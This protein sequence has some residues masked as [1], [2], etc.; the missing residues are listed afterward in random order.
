[1]DKYLKNYRNSKFPKNKETLMQYAKVLE[2]RIETTAKADSKLPY[3]FYNGLIQTSK[4]FKQILEDSELPTIDD[5][6]VYSIRIRDN[7]IE[8]LMR[9]LEPSIF[10]T[11]EPDNYAF[12]SETL[13]M[14]VN[15]NM[16]TVEQFSKLT[17]LEIPL[18]QQNLRRGKYP[19]A[20]KVSNYWLI[21]ELSVF[22]NKG[23]N[24]EVFTWNN[25]EAIFFDEFEYLSKF[26]YI[27]FNKEKY[28]KYKVALKYVSKFDDDSD[29]TETKDMDTTEKEK[30]ELFL[31]SNQYVTYQSNIILEVLI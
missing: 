18:I 9:K 23:R 4:E 15:C 27:E 17:G 3:P 25:N 1:M 7:G 2:N 21:P 28:G 8:L 14:K 6:W 31:I 26:N 10:E 12:T 11:S 29:V 5:F 13:I 24:K 22:M 30:I 20:I 16:L 19:S